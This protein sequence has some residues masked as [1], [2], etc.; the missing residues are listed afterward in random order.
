MKKLLIFVALFQMIFLLFTMVVNAQTSCAQPNILM[1]LDRS[2]RMDNPIGSESKYDVATS[3]VEGALSR[4]AGQARFG[5]GV[6]PMAGQCGAGRIL[7]EPGMEASNIGNLLNS[8]SPFGSRPIIQ[9]I[10]NLEAEESIHDPARRNFV[11]LIA[12]A[13][14][15]CWEGD[16]I[17]H[18]AQ[19]KVGALIRSGIDGL[20]VI[21]LGVNDGDVLSR[22]AAIG[23]YP[24]YQASNRGE[25]ESILGNI[26]SEVLTIREL[27]DGIDNNCNNQI[28]EGFENLGEVCSIGTGECL[29]EGVFV[30]K[31]DG[32]GVQCGDGLPVEVCDG[33]DNNCNGEIDEGAICLAQE[34]AGVVS[35]GTN[36]SLALKEDRSVYAWGSNNS[37]QLG[38]NSTENSPIP[39][40]VSGSNEDNF[41]TSIVLLSAGD[42]HSLVLKEDRTVYAW[43]SNNRGQLGNYSTD[44]SDIPVQVYG[45]NGVGFLTNI[46]SVSAGDEYSLALKQDGGVYAWGENEY[47]KLGNNSTENSY[48][49][50]KVKVLNGEEV[51]RDIVA[52]SAG[53]YHSLALKRDGT[54]YAWGS[55]YSGQ[56][57]VGDD[58]PVDYSSVAVQVKGLNG[59][60][61]LANI[62]AISAGGGHSLALKE[63][64]TVYAWGSNY[65]GQLGNGL[66]ANSNVPVQVYGLNGR[67]FLKDI[68]AVSAGYEHSLALKRDGTV[69]AW[70][71]NYNGRLGNNSTENIPVPVQVYDSNGRDFLTNIVAISAGGVHSS[72]LKQGG[73]VYSW[74][75]N[76]RGQLGNDSTEDSSVPVQVDNLTDV[77][78]ARGDCIAEE[79]VCDGEDND[80][81]GFRDEDD[82]GNPLLQ[83]CS[84]VCGGGETRYGAKVC[85]NTGFGECEIYTSRETCDNIDNDCDGLIDENITQTCMGKWGECDVAGNQQCVNGQMSECIVEFEFDCPYGQKAVC[86]GSEIQCVTCTKIDTTPECFEGEEPTADSGEI[87]E[88][89]ERECKSKI[90]EIYKGNP[91]TVYVSEFEKYKFKI[92]A[93][94]RL[95]STWKAT[96]NV[97]GFSGGSVLA[98]QRVTLSQNVRK[99]I[100]GGKV[101][102]TLKQSDGRRVEFLMESGNCKEKGFFRKAYD[103]VRRYFGGSKKKKSAP[104]LPMIKTKWYK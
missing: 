49:P 21:G 12:G 55:H 102:L 57:G 67:G 1:L 71:S 15:S 98:S 70:G 79:E 64:G 73:S 88:P 68:V 11:V 23:G 83:L 8:L 85:S 22:M 39:V 95:S 38:N 2:G 14:E 34:C 31:S 89:P 7:V 28:D 27:C 101:Y 17:A 66:N 45:L 40:Q 33:I 53:G 61:V 44:D 9:T 91:K 20:F 81:D 51:L 46:I 94:D 26:L 41:L 87:P 65:S 93:L 19:S 100:L 86:D 37:G 6:F 76:N 35:A 62:V 16:D 72:V 60:G 32:S 47:G 78:C 56:L 54:V 97:E 24:Y 103:K 29:T 82:Q 48:A 25:L 58:A 50:V 90:V 13:N 77:T 69:Y 5:L 80:C 74:G 10:S 84:R 96:L 59:E 104:V 30:C 4:H 52:I 43:G 36:Y 18:V 75:S 99:G 3:V 92:L 63:N 42:G